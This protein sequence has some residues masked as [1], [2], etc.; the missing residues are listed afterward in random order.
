M[1][2]AYAPVH[3]EV[4]VK[5]APRKQTN[6]RKTISQ[7]TFLVDEKNLCNGALIT[8]VWALYGSVSYNPTV[9]LR[10]RAIIV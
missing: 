10:M 6:K 9:S 4:D 7:L 5:F 8:K 1:W 3:A 2:H